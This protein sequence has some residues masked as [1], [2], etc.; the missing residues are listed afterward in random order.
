M[1][2]S[3]PAPGGP[4]D[5]DRVQRREDFARELS[6]LR[7]QAELTVRQ[8]AAKIGVQGAHTTVGD[9]FAG[10]GLPASASRDLLLRVL[11]VCGVRD[12]GQAERWLAAWRR[13][14]RA[15]GP[16]PAGPEPYRGLAGF[17]PE[18]AEWFFGRRALTGLLVDRLAT[19]AGVRV[20][21]GASGSGKSSLLRAG[22][23]AALRGG[24]LP[25]S[26]DWPIELFTPGPRPVEEL[27][28][29][30]AALAGTPV[31]GV[32]DAVRADPGRCADYAGKAGGG[33]PVLVIDQFEELFTACD[34]EGERRLF[35]AGVSAAAAG[36][37]LVVI[38]LRADFYAPALRHP[39]LVD[40][41]RAGQVTVGPMSAA[42]LREAIVEPAR[43]A[44]TPIED[45][46][47]ELLLRD[48]APAGR[49]TVGAHEPGV[50]PL[51]SHALDASWRHGRGKKLT[52]ADY[53]AVGG[54][55]GA[56]AATAGAV[57]DALSAEQQEVARRLFLHLVH[58]GTDTAD[59]RRRA[60]TT[61]LLA[62]RGDASQAETKD[63][64]DRFIAQRLIT[65]D[66]GTVEISHEALLTAW[67]RL[68]SW[69]DA[70][71]AGLI[72]GRRLV[73]AAES[74]QRDGRDPEALYRGA[75]LA[76]AQE[77]IGDHRAELPP[78]AL[79]FF[80]AS[81]RHARRRTRR[82]YQTIGALL[83]SLL[84]ALGASFAAIRAEG[85]A[86][87]QRDEALSRKV[88]A[89]TTAL[90]A[91]NPA[92]AAQLA[93][94][95]Y[96]LAPTAEARG[97][98]L[99]SLSAPF[100]TRVTGHRAT[101]FG[102]AF[103]PGGRILATASADAT[104]RLWN[105]TDVGRP[106]PLA[107]LTVHT[108]DVTDVTFSRDGELLATS[109]SDA[110]GKV[111]DVADPRRPRL[112]A[113]LTGH[114]GRISEI[115]FAPD[116]RTV[117]TVSEDETARLWDIT[118]RARPRTLATLPGVF[119]ETAFSP[120]GRTLVAA[121][122]DARVRRWDVADPAHPVALPAL[123]GHADRV[124]AAAFSPDGRT[125]ATGGFDNALRLWDVADPR[126][127]EFLAA[128]PGH[129]SGIVSIAF[130]ADGHTIATGSYDLTARLW[131]ISDPKFAGA[132]VT[133]GGHGDVV[134][135][136]AFDPSGGMLA[137]ASKDT[138]VRLWNV[139]SPVIGGHTGTVNAVAYR[140]DGKALLAGSYKTSQLLDLGERGRPAVRARPGGHTDNVSGAAFAPD[141][142]TLVTASLDRTLRLL[143]AERPEEP[144]A[145]L[146]GHTL[147]VTGVAYHP[148]GHIVASSSQ[149]TTARLWDVADR[150]RPVPL[151]V[152]PGHTDAVDDVATAPDGTLLAT[153]SADGTAR[154]W[155]ITVPGRPR[156]LATIIGHGNAV[157]NVDFHP[158]G[159]LLAT[160]GAD[161]TARLWDITAPAAPRPV[162]T[163]TGHANAVSDVVFHPGGRLLATASFDGT[164]RLWDIADPAAPGQPAVLAGHTA[165]VLS[166]AFSPD[167]STLVTGGADFTA[168]QW[169]THLGRVAGQV[170]ALAHPPVTRAEWNRYLPGTAFR[171][172]CP[173]PLSWGG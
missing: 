15:P 27:A 2:T 86:T 82:L 169:D 120:D 61:E 147:N 26:A 23:I 162:A 53:R 91:T 81:V 51:L 79:T 63:V 65:A 37:A 88:A 70:D 5:P 141:G 45:G 6:L 112:L 109:S 144:P 166:A 152:L 115:T 118:D 168:R 67:P 36:G 97:G 133:L 161:G 155:D 40:A 130:A 17:Q 68:R 125:L 132:P 3:S 57:Y 76:A 35:V 134:Y 25:G 135:G 140:P 48:V 107:E 21:V 173:G 101:V 117:A 41:V 34:D 128:L 43:R 106:L 92:L 139:R 78:L 93:L 85:T 142:R 165:R 49:H 4:P 114:A 69:L 159:R 14:R 16:R 19:G 171:P 12:P 145:R 22:L 47:V 73:A 126:R 129:E 143:D 7:E 42:E 151:A 98:L 31:A 62:A 146:I 10:R 138:T 113:T 95:A 24:A 158:G 102:V 103:H 121:G 131:D 33:R 116:G 58:L 90:R 83:L 149:D 99:S 172:P 136:V 119:N 38:A 72:A 50:L 96:R 123:I 46:L 154:L 105:V 111:W 29:R 127:P 55:D 9:W 52:V 11:D 18:D 164:V 44:K 71:R 94:A 124:L 84:L 1:P 60:T 28:A 87:R 8:V 108:D 150:R 148:R 54:I 75:R 156:P 167:G 64:L 74:W 30:L 39:Q 137:T 77:W 153:A 104:A 32:A 20:V 100:A 59:T 89:E 170:C 110:T 157:M 13:V 80:D 66:T 122:N 163:L 160:A 56:V